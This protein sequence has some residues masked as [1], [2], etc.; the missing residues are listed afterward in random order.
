M[1]IRMYPEYLRV[2]ELDALLLAFM[3]NSLHDL[4][5]TGWPCI[6]DVVQVVTWFARTLLR[7]ART[8]SLVCE[9]FC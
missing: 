2:R 1:Y 8:L 6:T 9:Y 5:N 4:V 3:L 7:P